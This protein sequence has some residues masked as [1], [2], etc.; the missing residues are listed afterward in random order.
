MA[1]YNSSIEMHRAVRSLGS[2]YRTRFL[3]GLALGSLG[4]CTAWAVDELGRGPEWLE[5]VE[6]ELPIPNLPS[7][8]QGK[9]VVQLSDLHC[10]TTVSSSYLKRCISRANQLN[11]DLIVLTGD[12]VTFDKRG[13]FKDKVTAMLGELEAKMGVYACMGNHDYGIDELGRSYKI[14][15][16]IKALQDNG[17]KVLRNQSR[18]IS[19]GSDKLW[20]IGLGDLWC[21][22]CQPIRAFASVP[23][24]APTIALVHNPEAIDFLKKSSADAILS[25]HT[26]GVK[27]QVPS[28]LLRGVHQRSL[29]GGMFEVNGKYLYINRGLGRHG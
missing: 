2:L 3:R 12:Y 27:N 20:L 29:V 5:I 11:P 21:S 4:F 17:I 23:Q 13:R 22:D 8:F 9:R 7:A 16:L 18:A 14:T 6:L 10:S 28:G 15:E 1:T 26:H 24:D 25:G 19:I